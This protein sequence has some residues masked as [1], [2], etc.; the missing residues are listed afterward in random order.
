MGTLP[1]APFERILKESASDIRVST[2]AAEALAEMAKEVSK[3]VAADAAEFAQHANRK[4]ILQQDVKLAA[5]R[6]F[7]SL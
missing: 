5:K 1:T 6:V 2:A 3:R 4:T 7:P